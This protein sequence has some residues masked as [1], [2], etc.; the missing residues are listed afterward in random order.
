MQRFERV[1]SWERLDRYPIVLTELACK[2][3]EWDDVALLPILYLH[4]VHNSYSIIRPMLWALFC[5]FLRLL[6]NMIYVLL[7]L[8]FVVFFP[9]FVY[10]FY[11]PCGAIF[12]N[13]KYIYI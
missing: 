11:T 6:I 2:Y 5:Y 7:L 4:I 1:G 13:Y 10:L 8:H 3:S 9:F 12:L